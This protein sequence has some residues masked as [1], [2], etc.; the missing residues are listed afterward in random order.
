[1]QIVRYNQEMATEIATLIEDSFAQYR[2]T[3]PITFLECTEPWTPRRELL[4][5]LASDRVDPRASHVALQGGKPVSAAM[6]VRSE[7]GCGWWRIATAAE[8]RRRGLAS[9]CVEAGESALREDGVRSVGTEAVVDSRWDAAETWLRSLGYELED[10]EKRNITMVAPDWSPRQVEWPD[11]FSLDTLREEDLDEWIAVRNEVFGSDHDTAWFRTRF[12]DRPDFDE[13]GW[14][15]VRHEGR[16][17]G[18]SSAVCVEDERDPEHL[19]G[20]QIEWV[21]VLEEF[22]GL[23]LGEKLVVACMNYAAERGFLPILLITQPFRVPAISLY[24]K[25]GFRTTAAW[26]SWRHDLS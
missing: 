12:M 13:S 16:M 4:D 14:K 24:E 7:D 18:I 2:N 26:H 3:T 21:G 22:R 1:M 5:T 9:A 23:R 8:H 10:P 19:R 17:I 6:A 11:G 25:L 15:I 20:A